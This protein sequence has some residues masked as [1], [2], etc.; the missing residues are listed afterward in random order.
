MLRNLRRPVPFPSPIF[1]IAE[2]VYPIDVTVTRFFLILLVLAAG[3]FAQPTVPSDRDQKYPFGRQ[4]PKADPKTDR[5]VRGIVRNEN[6]D[7]VSGAVVSLLNKSTKTVMKS[8]T[9]A[10]GS[11]LFDG[12]KKNVDYAL[13]AEYNGAISESRGVSSL[14]S[15][16]KL[17]LELR[18]PPPPPPK[19]A[20]KKKGS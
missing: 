18:L 16:Q 20:A 2:Q 9:G 17:Y 1:V 6:D 5:T 13:K 7:P 19:E 11:Y 10:D 3:A 12:L 15:R 14:D 4:P 8:A